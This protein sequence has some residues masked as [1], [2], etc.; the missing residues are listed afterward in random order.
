VPT[1]T[2]NR[3][4]R[5]ADFGLRA[6]AWSL[7]LFGLLQLDG[8]KSHF[9]LPLTLLQGRIGAG[10]CGTS[11]IPIETTL[12]CSG[13]DAVA[14]CLGVILAYPA[15]WGMRLAGS[16]GGLALILGLNTLRI[17]TLGRV[18]SSPGLFEILH[19][20]L[21]PAALMVA[22]AGYVFGWM[23]LSDG[24]RS[25]APLAAA[26]RGVPWPEP[27]TRRFIILTGVF[28]LLFVAASPLFLE[29]P[30][31]LAVAALIARAAAAILGLAG[32]AAVTSGNVL[33]TARGGFLVTQECIST[34]L[35]PVY[36]AAVLAFLRGWRHI[37]AGL[38]AAG[39][40][41]F[42]LGVARLLVVALPVA[43]PLLLVHAFYQI[44]LAVVLV[45]L[46][47]FRCH[48]ADG[49]APRRALLG[50]TLG[51]VVAR[52]LGEPYTLLVAREAATLGVLLRTAAA[53][54]PQLVDPQGAVALLPPFQMGFYLAL[55][56]AAF[57][58]LGWRWHLAGLALLWL[59]Q[60]AVFLLLPA[61]FA[62]AGLTVHV[63][64]IRAWA[65]I[66]PLAV[67]ALVSL[68]RC[69]GRCTPEPAPEEGEMDA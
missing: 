14:L 49:T 17:G 4:N 9:L 12:A 58:Y 2:V 19:V 38:L 52:L 8:V 30:L 43:S 20:Y 50:V 10:I 54:G 44:L 40:L 68:R 35:I 41:F 45:C 28:L 37:S 51:V 31:V 21:W 64:E 56:V 29:S 24:R 57:V 11:A 3:S 61:L 26:S 46:A 1:D 47:A 6:V 55:W 36:L 15:R 13:A 67:L 18:A 59:T 60:V 5:A 65:V 25:S 69:P 27:G 39:P 16:A 32:F 42:S 34:P 63:R 7:G 33:T 23:R 53:G 48:G 22:I 62:G 66:G